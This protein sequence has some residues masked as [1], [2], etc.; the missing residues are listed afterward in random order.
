MNG[1]NVNFV[2]LETQARA[3][4]AQ[5]GVDAK[6]W[7]KQVTLWNDQEAGIYVA[8]LNQPTELTRLAQTTVHR[9]HSV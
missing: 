7:L 9:L 8:A 4:L 3:S 5:H 2:E 1:F 6:S